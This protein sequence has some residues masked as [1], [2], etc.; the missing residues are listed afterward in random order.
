MFGFGEAKEHRDAVYEGRHEGKLSHEIVAGGAAF[1]AMKL[2]EDRQRKN[3]TSP[4]PVPSPDGIL[5]PRPQAD[6]DTGEP[7]KH[8]FAKEML[9][10]IAGAEVDKLFETKGLDYID[11]EKAKRHA[12]KQAEHLYEE[13]YGDMD[14]YN[15][16]R[17]GRHHHMNY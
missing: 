17:R 13:Q 9:V 3:G 10:G 7:V 2:F 1:E 8:A 16:E 12:E 4:R 5:R 11:R 14:E 15:P 6:T